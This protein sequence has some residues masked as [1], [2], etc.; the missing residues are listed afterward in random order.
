VLSVLLAH[1]LSS[2][3]GGGGGGIGSVVP[4]GD[5]ARVT[6]LMA[7]AFAATFWWALALVVIAFVVALVLLP[8]DKPLP[9]DD[10]DPG[11]SAEA[12]PPLLA[13]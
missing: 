1:E 2:R 6:P 3:L 8:K 13:H 7:D 9:V 5:R 12:P 4:A 10:P 11:Q